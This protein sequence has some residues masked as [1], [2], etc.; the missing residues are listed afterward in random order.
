[1]IIRSLVLISLF[2]VSLTAN[3]ATIGYRADNYFGGLG[4][5]SGFDTVFANAGHTVI[6]IDFNDAAA[7]NGVDGLWINNRGLLNA[8]EIANMQSF[9]SSGR[10]VVYMSDRSDSSTWAD[11]NNIVLP[12]VGGDDI[13]TGGNF[14]VHPVIGTHELVDGV[15]SIQFN[16]WSA[17]D[18]GI[19]SPELL[20]ANGMAAV[21]GFG[22]GELL[23]IGDTNWQY[24]GFPYAGRPQIFASNIEQWLTSPVTAVPEPTSSALFLLAMGGLVG[25]R[26]RRKQCQIAT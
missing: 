5:S 20:F 21:Y 4:G 9:L 13:I 1:M 11:P 25:M 17:V 16:T 22:G 6:A 10:N 18:P 19:G 15:G 24:N 7:V 12:A 3:A 8:T 26:R 23:F 2:F 14:G